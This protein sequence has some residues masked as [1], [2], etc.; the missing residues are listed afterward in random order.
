MTEEILDRAC[1]RSWRWSAAQMALDFVT[2]TGELSGNS[3]RNSLSHRTDSERGLC[4]AGLW[5]LVWLWLCWQLFGYLLDLLYSH[6]LFLLSN[7]PMV[8]QQNSAGSTGRSSGRFAGLSPASVSQL[9]WCCSL[10]LQHQQSRRQPGQV[11]LVQGLL[12]A[13]QPSSTASFARPRG[14]CRRQGDL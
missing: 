13:S 6:G 4:S 11:A 1:G 8:R 7:S 9:I 2:R 14:G 3:E 12:L 5:L 10:F